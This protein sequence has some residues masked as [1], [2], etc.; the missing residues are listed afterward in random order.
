MI[1][2]DALLEAARY[3]DARSE[4]HGLEEWAAQTD[5]DLEG[6]MYV[7]R[8][9]ALRAAMMMD[10]QDPGLLSRTE[11]TQVTLGEDAEAAM[12][13]LTAAVMDGIGIGVAASKSNDYGRGKR[14]GG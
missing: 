1:I 12:T 10:G 13:Y 8:Q 14:F 2:K 6:L 4:E 3:S 11:P 5:I 7:A 9:R